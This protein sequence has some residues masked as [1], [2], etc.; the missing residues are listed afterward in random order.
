MSEEHTQ[1]VRQGEAQ[2]LIEQAEA[3]LDVKRVMEAYAIYRD[4]A[5]VTISQVPAR[6]EYGTGGNS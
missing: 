3:S 2:R 1:S 5:A 6:V 4:A